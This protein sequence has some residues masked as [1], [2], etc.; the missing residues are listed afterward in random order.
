MLAGLIAVLLLVA[1]IPREAE[2]EIGAPPGR[3]PDE[4]AERS[5]SC[6]SRPYPESV[7]SEQRPAEDVDHPGRETLLAELGEEDLAGWFVLEASDERLSV[8]RE[9]AEPRNDGFRQTHD[10]VGIVLHNRQWKLEQWSSCVPRLAI[11]GFGDAELSLAAPPAPDSTDIELLV[12]EVACASG[13]D[14]TGRVRVVAL[15]ER[16]D[17]VHVIVGLVPNRGDHTCPSNP[18]TPFTLT[19]SEPLGDREL[20]NAAVWPPTPLEV[21]PALHD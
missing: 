7:W 11:E 2:V 9:L 14:A 21:A 17:A 5:Y 8:A 20:V 12:T 19:L 3:V 4:D 16:S 13:R 6:F 10:I 1:C 15:D 18:A